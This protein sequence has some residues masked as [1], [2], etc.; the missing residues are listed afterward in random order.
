MTTPA[1]TSRRI[2]VRPD[3]VLALA[4]EYQNVVR[5]EQPCALRIRPAVDGWYEVIVPLDV[6]LWHFHNLGKWFED[7]APYPDK[8]NN[9]ITVSDGDGDAAYFLVPTGEKKW[10]RYLVGATAKAST[11]QYD[12]MTAKVLDDPRL[13]V[14]STP[15]LAMMSRNVPYV[16]QHPRDEDPPG[17][18]VVDLKVSANPPA[19]VWT[20]PPGGD[21]KMSDDTGG[22]WLRRLF[23]ALFL[24]GR[25]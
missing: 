22:T 25:T 3:K 23:V 17:T 2:L 10:D 21:A 19:V 14:V 12:C 1:A 9:V 7:A 15:G 11:F 24:R 18:I 16:L 13:R 5:A 8:P 6:P 20:I 4:R